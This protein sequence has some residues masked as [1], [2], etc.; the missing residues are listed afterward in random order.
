VGHVGRRPSPVTAG[1]RRGSHGWD[2]QTGGRR[3]ADNPRRVECAG[4][5]LP[6]RRR[7]WIRR[8]AATSRAAANRIDI[9]N[10]PFV[11]L[12]AWETIRAI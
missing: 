9:P 7:Y 10:Q 4:K 5:R 6:E 1:D 11:L 8:L 3:F 12:L 2:C